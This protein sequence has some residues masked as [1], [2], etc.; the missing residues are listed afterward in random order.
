[1]ARFGFSVDEGTFAVCTSSLG[2][3][4]LNGDPSCSTL[5]A[6]GRSNSVVEPAWCGWRW[7]TENTR[8][9]PHITSRFFF[10]V[11]LLLLLD[12]T[13]AGFGQRKLCAKKASCMVGTLKTTALGIGPLRC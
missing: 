6:T 5:V 9:V 4:S 11:S 7:S 1:M 3:S 8:S 13:K 2:G 12:A 10:Y